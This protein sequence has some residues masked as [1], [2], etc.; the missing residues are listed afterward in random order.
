VL[1]GQL[2]VVLAQEKIVVNQ[3][4]ALLRRAVERAPDEV[5]LDQVA[6]GARRLGGVAHR[7]IDLHAAPRAGQRLQSRIP[8]HALNVQTEV[9]RGVE[10]AAVQALDDAREHFLVQVTP[11]ATQGPEPRRREAGGDP[12]DDLPERLGVV[13]QEPLLDAARV[14]AQDSAPSRLRSRGLV[15]VERRSVRRLRG[16][17]Q[18]ERMI[19]E[20]VAWPSFSSLEKT[21]ASRILTPLLRNGTFRVTP[22]PSP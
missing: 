3:R 16:G 7:R 9:A 20:W 6:L 2:G 1:G 18:F 22:V 17:C 13:R 19:R 12:A 5:A 15:E 4:A 10:P 14:V 21:T 8:R 11:L